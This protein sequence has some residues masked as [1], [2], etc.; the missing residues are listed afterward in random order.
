MNIDFKSQS[1]HVHVF[2]CKLLKWHQSQDFSDKWNF[3]YFNVRLIFGSTEL[4]TWKNS[5][6]IFKEIYYEQVANEL[7]I[8]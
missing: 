1:T 5:E 3:S 6:L 2:K 7:V 4:S 8:F